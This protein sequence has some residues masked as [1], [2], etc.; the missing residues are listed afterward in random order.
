MSNYDIEY[1]SKAIEELTARVAELESKQ[2][3]QIHWSNWTLVAPEPGTPESGPDQ[4]VECATN[5]PFAGDTGAY[6]AGV[7]TDEQIK[8]WQNIRYEGSK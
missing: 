8:E 5:N 2:P 1:L 7:W 4:W 3:P 6:K